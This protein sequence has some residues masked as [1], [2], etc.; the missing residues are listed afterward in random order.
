MRD[1]ISIYT[2]Y[3]CIYKLIIVI[4]V[5]MN[6]NVA[7]FKRVHYKQQWKNAAST[8]IYHLIQNFEDHRITTEK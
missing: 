6:K 5:G 7:M 8:E 3:T 1:V 4:I 2:I